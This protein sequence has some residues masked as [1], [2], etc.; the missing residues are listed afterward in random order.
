[1]RDAMSMAAIL[2]NGGYWFAKRT[3][4]RYVMTAIYRDGK[5]AMTR[6]KDGTTCSYFPHAITE[7]FERRA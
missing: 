1:M 2:L 3:G 7:L 4:D 6:E 5:V